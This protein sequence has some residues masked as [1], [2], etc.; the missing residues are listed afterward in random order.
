MHHPK[1]K[2]Y[3]HAGIFSECFNYTW[4]H[5]KKLSLV[6]LKTLIDD[7]LLFLIWIDCKLGFDQKILKPEKINKCIG[8]FLS[9]FGKSDSISSRNWISKTVA[10]PSGRKL[11][12]PTFL[13]FAGF[14]ES[15]ET[16]H[17]IEP[18]KKQRW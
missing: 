7:H 12:F 10:K 1:S 5:K 16:L 17:F 2:N 8:M 13:F 14:P 18:N 4:T 3:D 6:F 9:S 11:G 15:E